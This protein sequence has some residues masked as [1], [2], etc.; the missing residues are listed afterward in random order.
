MAE[1]ITNMVVRAVEPQSHE[2]KDGDSTPRGSNEPW[3]FGTSGLTPSLMDPHSQSFNM[4]AN[5]MPGYYTPTP[6]GTSTLY[7]N[8][9]GD[10]H[11]P[12]L[13]GG[14]GTPL[15]L[16]TSEGALHAGHQA[17]AFHGFHNQLSQHVHPQAFQNV[18]PF[19]MHHPTSFPPHQFTHQPS[20]EHLD[21]PVGESPIEDL[22]LDMHMHPHHHSPQMPFHSQSLHNAMK[23]T[24]VHP[25]AEKYV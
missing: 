2:L 1:T 13:G 23:P 20:F 6:G 9:A 5:Q 8:Q 14:L 24:H 3:H 22:G 12:G 17:T 19:Q 7:H 16:P 10:L 25:S 18:N 4:F 11:T 21:G 15:S